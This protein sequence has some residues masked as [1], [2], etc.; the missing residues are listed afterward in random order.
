MRPLLSVGRKRRELRTRLPSWVDGTVRNAKE[1]TCRSLTQRL[2][3]WNVSIVLGADTGLCAVLQ[4][5]M[6]GS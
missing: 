1:E 6:V 2:S 3:R 5:R 4:R